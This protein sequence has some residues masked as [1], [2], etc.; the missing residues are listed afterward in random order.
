MG[1]IELN[2]D[3]RNVGDAQ[4]EKPAKG[5]VAPVLRQKD[6]NTR[7]VRSSAKGR[8][9]WERGLKAVEPLLLEAQPSVP[10]DSRRRVGDPQDRNSLIGPTRRVPDSRPS[11]APGVASIQRGTVPE[12]RMLFCGWWP[13]T[14]G[15]N[16]ARRARR[17][18]RRGGRVRKGGARCRRLWTTAGE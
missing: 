9:D 18:R 2:R 14:M 11:C 4:V 6:P 16:L 3:G 5:G 1:G 13:P 7:S 15:S 17:A 12:V 8:E 10:N